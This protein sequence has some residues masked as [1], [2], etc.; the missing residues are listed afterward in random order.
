MD[1]RISDCLTLPL[2]T[3][4]FILDETTMV[5]ALN[6]LNRIGQNTG[7][8]TL[9]AVK[10]CA[11]AFALQKMIPYIDGFATSSVFET[12]I[13]R[14]IAG[15]RRW[16]HLT[17]P[18]ISADELSEITEMCDFLSF[19]SLAQWERYCDLV[20]GKVSCGLRINLQL[21]FV[22]DKRYDP[23]RKHSKLG[24]ALH[25]LDDALRSNSKRTGEIRG[26]HFHN[27]CESLDFAELVASIQKLES[28]L[29]DLLVSMDWINIGGGYLFEEC[30]NLDAMAEAVGLLQRRYGLSVA[31]EPGK[32][33]IGEAGFIVATIVDI[34]KSDGRMIAVLDTTIN[35]MPEVFEYQ[36][37]PDIAQESEEGTY[38]YI[39]AGATCLAGDVFGEYRFDEPLEIGSRIV[40]ENM[41]AYT[42][43]KANMFNGI[44]LPTIYAYT[45]DGKLEMKKQFTY[46]DFRS[47]CGVA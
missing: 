4:A 43:V 23:C 33:V 19:N 15:T 11:I 13:A 25:M 8:K 24:V 1:E 37:K 47:R 38:S 31:F 28:K 42:L 6:T 41:G 21:S 35:H 29:K 44:N 46:E 5:G 17:K 26:I 12:K 39:L 2:M 40:F 20:R 16:V 10:S 3:P 9:F 32:G 22:R 27:N 14:S 30:A 45:Q 34:F 7:I 36:Y 18:G